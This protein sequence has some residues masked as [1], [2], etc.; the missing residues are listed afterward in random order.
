VEGG[1]DDALGV[2]VFLL[3]GV[4]VVERMDDVEEVD[5]AVEDD[6]VVLRTLTVVDVDA[7]GLG[8][9][10]LPFRLDHI[11]WTAQVRELTVIDV[12]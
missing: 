3:T 9:K 6:V 11:R 1:S 8:A 12:A 7:L 5:V 2:A 10:Q 4:V